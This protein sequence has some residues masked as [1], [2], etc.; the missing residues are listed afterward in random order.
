MGKRERINSRQSNQKNDEF[1]GD[2]RLL[3]LVEMFGMMQLIFGEIGKI[4]F[5][6]C[7]II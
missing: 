1:N 4:V 7:V 2:C 6:Y 3:P 5:V